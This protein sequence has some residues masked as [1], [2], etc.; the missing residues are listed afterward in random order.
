M[1][2]RALQACVRAGAAGAP[3]AASP[4][5]SPAGALLEYVDLALKDS[6]RVALRTDRAREK[7]LLHLAL[8]LGEDQPGAVVLSGAP[9]T[10]RARQAVGITAD[11]YL[12]G[13]TLAR[14]LGAPAVSDAELVAALEQLSGSPDSPGPVAVVHSGGKPKA[15][16]ER[17]RVAFV[18]VLVGGSC[19]LARRLRA[20]TRGSSGLFVAWDFLS[21]Q[22]LDARLASADAS[23]LGQERRCGGSDDERRSGWV[24]MPY[25]LAKTRFH[26]GSHGAGEAL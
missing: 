14:D 10:D 26:T 2:P 20:A 24:V 25:T 15:A 18:C 4:R 6:V 8:R 22:H 9:V 21:L 23:P 17:P 5:E 12:I 19:V 16:G 1:G 3:V 11:P 13:G 7:S